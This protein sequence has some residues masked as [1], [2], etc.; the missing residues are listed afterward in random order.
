MDK[1]AIAMAKLA[2]VLSAIVDL[3]KPVVVRASMA[4]NK[5]GFDASEAAQYFSSANAQISVLRKAL[6]DLFD[7]FPDLEI[8]P[9]LEIAGAGQQ[10]AAFSRAQLEGLCRAIRQ[11]FEIRANSNLGEIMPNGTKAAKR[12]VFISH[13]R[14]RDW[15]EVQI[16][17][18][19]DLEDLQL[20]TSELAQEPS[21]GMTIIEKLE[22]EA[23]NCDSAVIVMSGDDKDENEKLRTRENVMHEIGYFQALYG[24][25]NVV[26]LHEDGVSVPTNLAGIVYSPYPKDRI[27]ASFALLARELKAMYRS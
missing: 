12:K 25:A 19:R 9:S 2:G 8:N 15:L 14:S 1:V 5:F 3:L 18:L 11:V 27:S 4:E 26:L 17:I 16:Y 6:P 13:G 20:Q 23:E 21:R 10:R 22:A 24:R 7:D